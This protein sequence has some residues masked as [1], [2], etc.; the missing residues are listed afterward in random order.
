LAEPPEE[1]EVSNELQS[2]KPS[3]FTISRTLERGESQH[4]RFPRGVELAAFE[5]NLRFGS[6]ASSV[7]RGIDR[8]KATCSPREEATGS[9]KITELRHGNAANGER[10]GVLSKRHLAKR[11]ERIGSCESTSRRIEIGIHDAVITRIA[12]DLL[13]PRVAPTA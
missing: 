13:L 6:E 2:A 4:Q 5:C 11:T 9:G 3:V 7:R 12:P 10:R 1:H 8:T